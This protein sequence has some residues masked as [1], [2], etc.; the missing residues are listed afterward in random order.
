MIVSDAE[1]AIALLVLEEKVLDATTARRIIE[2]GRLE[3]INP[4]QLIKEQVQEAT[5]LR[6]VARLMGTKFI[7]LFAPKMEL[8]F[9]A[10]L[11]NENDLDLLL[12]YVAIPMLNEQNKVIVVAANPNDYDL[13]IFLKNRYPTGFS[14]TLGSKGQIQNKL[15]L[16]APAPEIAPVSTNITTATNRPRE[17]VA[18]RSPMQD[19]LDVTLSRAVAEGASDVHFM[20]LQ[21]K[22]IMLRFRID[23]ILKVQQMNGQLKG[24]EIIAAL[25]TRCSTM[26]PTNF[27]APQDGTFSF[28]AAGRQIDCRVAVLPQANGPTCVVRLLDSQNMKIRLDDMGFSPSHLRLIRE[29]MNNSQ[30]TILAV[31]PTGQGKTT[32]LYS[33]LREVNALEK[34]V[35][36]VED[37][38][39]YRLPNIGQTEVKSTSNDKSITFAK[40]LRAMLRMDPDVILVGEIRDSET[41]EVA[42]QAAITGHLVLSSLHANSA[43]SSYNRLNNMGLPEYLSSE[44]I[45]LIISQRLLRRIHECREIREINN[46]ERAIYKSL[47]LTPPEM[48]AE[49]KG[50]NGCNYTGFRGRIAAVEVLNPTNALR[51]LL[52]KKVSKDHLL[53]QAKDEGFLTI[54]DDGARHVREFNTTP[55]EL[56]RVLSV[57]EEE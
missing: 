55:L 1:K 40:A 20:F 21:D 33:M 48:V 38:V 25:L 26:D 15:A 16:F 37:P 5:L 43:M 4:T 54:I 6:G 44:A 49:P 45:S 56:T 50:C 47:H 7:D 14:L 42:M 11:M 23:G 18:N 31:G 57:E 19:W 39:E 22:T 46:E 35:L 2:R 27:I 9:D 41:A 3:K 10:S 51:E 52:Y 17:Y 30:G 28:E 34:N 24:T 29:K 53:R 36:T 8:K 32:T 13:A 12:Q